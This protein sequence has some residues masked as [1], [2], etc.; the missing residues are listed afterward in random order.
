MTSKVTF[1]VEERLA[2]AVLADPGSRNA[3]GRELVDGL[4]GVLDRAFAD[5]DVGA[6]LI[7]SEGADFSAGGDLREMALLPTRSL[8]EIEA[9]GRP[10]AELFK[11]LAT[12][13]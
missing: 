8:A 3:M 12:A 13:P 9:G 11:R 10:I 4:N 7:T 6:I 2:T 5:R 1:T